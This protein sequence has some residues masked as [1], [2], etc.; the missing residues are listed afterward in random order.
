[1]FKSFEKQ[2]VVEG[3]HCMHCAKKVEDVLKKIKGVKKVTVDLD[4]GKVTMI[5]KNEIDAAVINSAI[6]QLGYKVK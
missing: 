3:M 4:S 2:F 1:M 6:E 5:S